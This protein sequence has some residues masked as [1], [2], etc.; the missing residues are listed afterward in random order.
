MN[1]FSKL[2]AAGLAE[3]VKTTQIPIRLIEMSR[4]ENLPIFCRIV[5]IL[6]ALMRGRRAS[7]ITG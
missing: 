5:S 3:Y 6:H 4:H 2:L 7:R 1:S